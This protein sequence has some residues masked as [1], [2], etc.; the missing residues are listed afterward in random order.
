MSGNVRGAARAFGSMVCEKAF[1]PFNI[2][3]PCAR[4]LEVRQHLI[5]C[6]RPIARRWRAS[7]PRLSQLQEAGAKVTPVAFRAQQRDAGHAAHGHHSIGE[8]FLERA[9]ESSRISCGTHDICGGEVWQR[10][11]S[12]AWVRIRNDLGAKFGESAQ[13]IV[14][15]DGPTWW[16]KAVASD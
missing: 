1:P 2:N 6:R 12:G 4:G 15:V 8:E 14:C 16:S 3:S 5:H 10:R 7:H 13:P 9:H 11:I